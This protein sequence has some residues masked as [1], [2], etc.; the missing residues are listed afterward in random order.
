VVDLELLYSAPSPTTYAALADA[1][2]GM[3]RVPITDATL[4]RASRQR[5]LNATTPVLVSR[6]AAGRW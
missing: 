6:T 1:L 4:E 2:R 5:G 3:P